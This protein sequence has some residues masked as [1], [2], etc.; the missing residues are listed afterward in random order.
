MIKLT[1][2]LTDAER[3]AMN[4]GAMARGYYRDDRRIFQPGWGWFERCYFDPENPK[5]DAKGV[6]PCAPRNP[7]LSI[8]Y[9]N[10]WSTK[11]PP[12]CV[13]LPNGEH[14]EMDRK[15]SN[16]TGW[17]VTGDWPNLTCSPSIAAKGYHGF[18]QGG[19]F[20]ADCERAGQPDGVYPYPA[21]WR[22]LVQFDPHDPRLVYIETLPG[23]PP[24]DYREPTPDGGLVYGTKP[25]E[26]SD[27]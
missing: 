13:V 8:H 25:G 16:G 4:D 15:S 26:G 6:Y 20:T 12:I 17:T 14:W 23:D 10:D 2:F 3:D 22:R 21:T 24:S 5:V 19:A 1:R 27:A 7:F 18:L 9:W 11:R